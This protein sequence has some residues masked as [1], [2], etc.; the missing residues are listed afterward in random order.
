MLKLLYGQLADRYGDDF[1]WLLVNESNTSF[2]TELRSE[3]NSGHSLLEKA[4]MAVAKSDSND[5]VLFLLKEE[6]YAIVHLTYSKNNASGFPL[7]K[8]FPSIKD[9]MNYIEE[10]FVSEYRN[11]V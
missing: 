3:L 8:I 2:I 4:V 6:K 1:N 9:A 5:D 7:Y 11:E 10:R